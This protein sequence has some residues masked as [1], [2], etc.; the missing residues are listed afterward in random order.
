MLSV[1]SDELDLARLRTHARKKPRTKAGQVRQAW[2]EIRNLLAAG[3]TLKDVCTWVNEIGIKISYT[4]LSDYVNQLRRAERDF[5]D[6]RSLPTTALPIRTLPTSPPM[7]TGKPADTPA[8]HDT[9]ANVHDNQAASARDPFANIRRES[10]RKRTS[11]FNYSPFR[12]TATSEATNADITKPTT[13]SKPDDS[14]ANAPRS[15][16]KLKRPA[17]DYPPELA[18]PNKLI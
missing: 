17:F 10:E 6:S 1:S 12:D 9:L 7:E 13:G 18:D 2:P 8:T 5:A 11:G 15:K 3:H 4:R 16:E 14:R